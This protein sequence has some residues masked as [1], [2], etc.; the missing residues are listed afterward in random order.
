MQKNFIDQFFLDLS[1]KVKEPTEVIITGA[2]AGF[3][4]GHSRQSLDIDF[5]IRSK[6]K[7]NEAYLEYLDGVV[8]EISARRNI[9]VNFGEDISHWSMIDYL[10]YREKSIRYKKIGDLDVRLM[11]PEHWTIGKISR[12][13]GIDI[14]D[15]IH[16]IKKQKIDPRKLINLWAR[17][18]KASP[19]SLAKKDFVDHVRTFIKT[20][21]KRTWGKDFDVQN[22]LQKFNDL[23]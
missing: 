8:R 2:V 19:L 15:V 13:V 14:E 16:V 4:F 5:E 18:L 17:A 23:I 11:A 9:A 3:L 10:D 6:K 12:F 21:G 20:Y 7:R 1:K 22:A